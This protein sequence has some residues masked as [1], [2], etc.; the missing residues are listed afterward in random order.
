[1]IKTDGWMD[2]LRF[3]V[4]LNTIS[5][6]QDDGRMIMKDVC[7]GTPFMVGLKQTRLYGI[8]SRKLMKCPEPNL[9]S[10]SGMSKKS[11]EL[12]VLFYYEELKDSS[13][14]KA[15]NHVTHFLLFYTC[16]RTERVRKLISTSLILNEFSCG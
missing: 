6:Y 13:L 15:E 10:S 14:V 2:D 12:L 1:M 11:S 3:N 8:C 4:L 9:I 7:N 16:I 5:V